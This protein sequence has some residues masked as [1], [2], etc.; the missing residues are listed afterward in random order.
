MQNSGNTRKR[1][2]FWSKILLK[3]NW[4]QNM[5]QHNY[6]C[7]LWKGSC[8]DA[9]APYFDPN[10]IYSG[11]LAWQCRFKTWSFCCELD[12]SATILWTSAVN[13]GLTLVRTF[14]GAT[15][16]AQGTVATGTGQ[17]GFPT[18]LDSYMVNPK[19]SKTLPTHI[20][21]WLGSK[22]KHNYSLKRE[23]ERGFSS[24]EGKW[25]QSLGQNIFPDFVCRWRADDV[26]K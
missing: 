16:P 24:L 6:W 12:L 25:F 18:T 23:R 10:M 1:V 9:C 21:K 3:V 5:M 20:W 7:N 22:N 17:C 2:R 19:Q 4:G 13:T 26:W 8:H 15:F 11:Y 14:T